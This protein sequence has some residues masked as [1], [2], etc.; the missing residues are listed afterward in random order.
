[1]IRCLKMLKKWIE[2]LNTIDNVTRK[3][4]LA[5]LAAI[6]AAVAIISVGFNH[7]DSDEV[8][9]EETGGEEYSLQLALADDDL[10]IGENQEAAETDL[11]ELSTEKLDQMLQAAV[12]SESASTDSEEI[13]GLE[14][15]NSFI[16]DDTDSDTKE[17]DDLLAEK[18]KAREAKRAEESQ[19]PGAI[20]ADIDLTIDEED[21]EPYYIRVNCTT[22]VVTVYVKDE[23]G[24]YTIP[25]R[26]MV[27]SVGLEDHT[28]RG[29]FSI[30]NKYDWKEL[31]QNTWGQYACRFD[32][33]ILFHSVP[34]LKKDASTLESEEYN[35]LGEAASL[36]CV[37]LAVED[38]KW[39]Y[40]NCPIGT[41]VEVFDGAEDGSDDPLGKPVSIQ[42]DLNSPYAGWDPTDPSEDNPWPDDINE[43]SE[44][45]GSTE[46]EFL[47]PVLSL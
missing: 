9:A 27:C 12:D 17:A 15:E 33:T 45:S 30:T 14:D 35:K 8:R 43:Q 28:R 20:V 10:L 21:E 11:S 4:I 31:F 46:A 7:F 16:N 1:M 37:R 34:Y 5:C 44:T 6:M 40:D 32:G 13:C 3:Q 36:G 26:A 25:Y 19:K 23:Q 47:Q 41:G 39:I 24:E 22:N 18:E 38:C 2:R 42:I 29:T